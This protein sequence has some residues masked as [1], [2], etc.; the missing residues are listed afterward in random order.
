[1]FDRGPTGPRHRF[2]G[3]YVWLLPQL[4]LQSPRLHGML[5]DWQVSGVVTIESGD[6]FTVT[7]GK[8]QS[9]T[10]LGQD[11][12]VQVGP[13]RGTGACGTRIPCVDWLNPDSFQLPPLGTFGTIRKGSLI[14]P[15]SF[16]WD[17][18]LFKNFSLAGRGRLQFRAEF[19]NVFNR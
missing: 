12:G 5:G 3:S 16:T 8:D 14:G 18:G 10:G 4:P 7:A 19:F 1:D 2:V 15:G 17:M 13:A 11:R 9:Q 6:S